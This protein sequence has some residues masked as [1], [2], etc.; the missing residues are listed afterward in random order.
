MLN[1]LF[2]GVATALVLALFG[3]L[4]GPY[5]VDWTQYRDIVEERAE[6]ALGTEVALLGEIE[7]RLLPTPRIALSDVRLGPRE[8]P[9][10]EAQEVELALDLPPLLQGD[11]RVRDLWL[12]S[13]RFYL[14][15]DET[16]TPRLRPVVE[17]LRDAVP[18]S[19]GDV[20]IEGVA[21]LA[22]ELVVEDPRR[23]TPLVLSDID[24]VGSAR[25]LVGPFEVDGLASAGGRTA[26]LT[27]ETGRIAP[28]GAVPVRARIAPVDA[29]LVLALS[30]TA[31]LFGDRPSFAGEARLERPAER[32]TAEVS[33][34]LGELLEEVRGDTGLAVGPFTLAGRLEADPDAVEIS[35]IALETGAIDVAT[36]LEG[37]VRIPLGEDGT[38]SARIAARQVDLDRMTGAGPADSEGAGP[39]ARA[40]APLF[41]ALSGLDLVGEVSVAIDTVIAGGD[42]VRDVALSAVTT[43]DGLT[44]ERLSADLPGSTRLS[45]RGFLAGGARPSFEG[46]VS[47]ESGQPARLVRWL[48]GGSAPMPIVGTDLSVTTSLAAGGGVVL[49]EDL[50]IAFG[51]SAAEGLLR[52]QSRAGR[53]PPGLF[54][55][56][57]SERLDLVAAADLVRTV[58]ATRGGG[59]LLSFRD[60]ELELEIDADTV[61]A[62]GF[63]G[64]GLSADLALRY[65]TLTVDRF[66]L[67]S[68]GGATITADGTIENLAGDPEGALSARIVADD[69]AGLARIGR[70]LAPASPVTAWFADAAPALAPLDAGLDVEGTGGDRLVASLAGTAGGTEIALEATAV[71]PPADPVRLAIEATGEATAARGETLLALAGLPAIRTGTERPGR[72]SLALSGVPA[73]GMALD[74]GASLLGVEGTA[75]GTL[76]V[77][78]GGLA[79]SAVDL[80]L[81]SDDVSD[82]A[83]VAGVTFPDLVGA[84]PARLAAEADFDAGRLALSGID[85]A[86]ADVAA[87]GEAA[88][89]FADARPAL[90]GK[91]RVSTVS[92]AFL[93]ELALGPGAFDRLPD[94]LE[95]GD[96][97]GPSA[98]D[99]RWPATPFGPPRLAGIDLDLALSTDRLV[100]AGRALSDARLAVERTGD[101]LRIDEASAALAGGRL[102]G[103]LTL[104]RA[105]D[106]ATAEG[107]VTVEAASLAGIGPP[108]AGGLAAT[109]TLGL[110]AEFSG[111][112]GS[113]AEI[114]AGLSG[115]GAIALTDL[116]VSGIGPGPLAAARAAADADELPLAEEAVA[117]FA[118]ARLEGERVAVD[119]ADLT[120]SVVGGEVVV[121]PAT[122]AVADAAAPGG[123]VP[124]TDATLTLGGEIGLAAGTID[125]AVRLAASDPDTPRADPAIAVALS[126]PLADARRS[127]AATGLVNYLTIR[128]IE[129]QMR[130]VERLEAEIGLDRPDAAGDAADDATGAARPTGPVERPAPGPTPRRRPAPPGDASG[131]GSSD[132]ARADPAAQDE[133]R[134]LSGENARAA[135]TAPLREG[136]DDPLGRLI[137]DERRLAEREADPFPLEPLPPPVEVA[138]PPGAGPFR[139]EPSDL[140]PVGEGAR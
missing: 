84:V 125:G 4:I 61:V 46:P 90:S 115:S 50:R 41:G 9:A 96:G 17:R 101:A 128:E 117:A 34:A 12:G 133:A 107:R 56:L 132:A 89:A 71:G 5:F 30:G 19:P 105:G 14:R 87:R 37:S 122:V 32:E 57:R 99:T 70:R 114:V 121:S 27:I 24:L 104:E 45:A 35:G 80:S 69:V 86:L 3:A 82:A 65:G 7:V 138:P 60:G 74:L 68:F 51:A 54:L 94:D 88:L 28:G 131:T 38:F 111:G 136:T 49:A 106:I 53:R 78:D 62:D 83:L 36:G 6:A 103:A 76:A 118:A 91:L 13:P 79:L 10:M 16:G 33:E 31:E 130:E 15:L 25:S 112:G 20:A 22:G 93:S 97:A 52:W 123:D 43:A 100:L 21:M 18:V 77:A 92:L 59:R 63:T 11:V 95:Q 135:A 23:E 98:G 64:D 120:F 67:D 85:A 134:D 73:D 113:L 39:A 66:G 140:A 75:R 44:I 26:S 55:T 40:A 29:P 72:V 108:A 129:R 124:F 102:S 116:V 42:L 139:L 137:E 47:V 81:E 2:I 8:A 110:A 127:V 1:G 58:A 109:G 119:R 48:R 126:G